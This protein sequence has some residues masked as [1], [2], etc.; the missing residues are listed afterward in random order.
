[1]SRVASR[2]IQPFNAVYDNRGVR[3]DVEY[4]QV[5]GRGTSRK[6]TL[7]DSPVVAKDRS[8]IAG[9]V[10]FTKSKVW[11]PGSAD[12]PEVRSALNGLTVLTSGK[13]LTPADVRKYIRPVGIA[14]KTV[15]YDTVNTNIGPSDQPVLAVSGH[16]TVVN[17]GQTSIPMGHAVQVSLPGK[18]VL[19][20]YDDKV[21][22][23]SPNRVV[24]AYES[25]KMQ[26]TFKGE[27]AKNKKL[28][29]AFDAVFAKIEANNGPSKA[30]SQKML[31][32]AMSSSNPMDQLRMDAMLAMVRAASMYQL[33]N[34]VCTSLTG[35]EKGHK[36][37]LNVQPLT[38]L[39][40]RAVD[41][42]LKA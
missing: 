16:L 34:Y 6:R 2:G 41:I 28:R 15:V 31:E 17:T 18:E 32:G 23:P 1:M 3:E 38:N 39:V 40:S 36:I 20:Q 37:K 22:I 13:D 11:V 21:N 29:D 30:D 33:R 5:S 4:Q 10:A 19:N 7:Y 24:M 14:S 27:Y 26:H 25:L 42:D 35:A 9:E 12:D 8:I